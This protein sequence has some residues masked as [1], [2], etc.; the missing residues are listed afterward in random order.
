MKVNFQLPTEIDLHGQKITQSDLKIALKNEDYSTI[1]PIIDGILNSKDSERERL[2]N[3]FLSGIQYAVEYYVKKM[4]GYFDRD[5]QEEI[6]WQGISY[7]WENLAEFDETKSK[8]ITWVS[9]QVKYGSRNSR[10]KELRAKQLLA[11]CANNPALVAEEIVYSG[12][13]EGVDRRSAMTG[14]PAYSLSGA[15]GREL[16]ESTK[17]ENLALREALDLLKEN[18]RKLIIMRVVEQLEVEEIAKLLGEDVTTNQVYVACSR[19]MKRYRD[20]YTKKLVEGRARV[21]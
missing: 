7:V 11:K 18:D 4:Y 12:K 2:F 5:T 1:R 14:I 15:I 21:K 3:F 17:Q 6:F 16:D 19:A 10:R 9:N 20:A 13:R 8:L